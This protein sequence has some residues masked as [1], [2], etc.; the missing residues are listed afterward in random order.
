MLVESVAESSCLIGTGDLWLSNMTGLKKS[1][2][3]PGALFVKKYYL[4]QEK[5]PVW[6]SLASVCAWE[7]ETRKSG[8]EEGLTRS[9]GNKQS[10]LP[11]WFGSIILRNFFLN[12]APQFPGREVQIGFM[13]IMGFS[14]SWKN[15]ASWESRSKD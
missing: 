12:W 2:E 14:I 3:A 11:S 9:H 15:K 6:N 8:Q 10:N 1:K 5:Y 13:Y 7:V 4:V